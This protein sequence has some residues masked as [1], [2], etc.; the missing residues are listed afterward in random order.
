MRSDFPEIELT[1][2]QEAEAE[3]IEEMLNARGR[4]MNRHMARLLASK[5]N[6]EL[7]GETEFQVRAAVHRLG[8]IGV[9]TALAER[10]KRGTKGPAS[11]ARLAAATPSSADIGSVE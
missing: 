7:F 1:A 2:E 11:S 10:K 3:K 9:E 6:R 5:P 8:A 4:D